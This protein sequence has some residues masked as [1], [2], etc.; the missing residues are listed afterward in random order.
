MRFKSD[1]LPLT[2]AFWGE[3]CYNLRGARKGAFLAKYAFGSVDMSE[4]EGFDG[5]ISEGDITFGYI[6]G[7]DTVLLIKT[8]QGGSISG[9]EN[10]YINLAKAVSWRLGFSVVVSETICDKRETYD[11]EMNLIKGLFENKSCQIYYFGV[12]KGGLIGCWYGADNPDIKRIMTVNMPL[13]VNFH[14]K[15]KP[16]IKALGRE[17]LTMVF[18]SRDPSYKYVPF[19]EKYGGVKILMGADHNLSGSP[20]NLWE[21]VLL[22][23]EK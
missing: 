4:R 22:I 2:I 12:S 5:V 21:L 10:K 20:V 6:M 17:R 14:N 19:V 23:V 3:Q 9:Y 7:S 15:T 11:R 18:G 1:V 8:G 16:A 13:M